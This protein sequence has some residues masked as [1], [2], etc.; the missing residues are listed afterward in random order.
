MIIF[1]I[2]FHIP[3]Y[4]LIPFSF[5]CTAGR[6]NLSLTHMNK[7]NCSPFPSCGVNFQYMVSLQG[8]W[9][10]ILQTVIHSLILT[11]FFAH[12][13]PFPLPRKWWLIDWRAGGLQWQA[14][15]HILAPTLCKTDFSRVN[16]FMLRS[17][18]Q[19]SDFQPKCMLHRFV[20]VTPFPE[21]LV[22]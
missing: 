12:Y 9:L 18:A 5:P 11:Q 14:E 3:K 13:L 21:V 8:L 10:S 15:L 6:F 19:P 1:F 16:S 20:S 2:T 22:C 7:Y 17:R 4:I